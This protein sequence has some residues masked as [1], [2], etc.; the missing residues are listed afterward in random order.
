MTWLIPRKKGSAPASRQA[1]APVDAE[2]F[3]SKLTNFRR[4]TATPERFVTCCACARHDRAFVVV[5][6]R[7][8]LTQ[9][10][11]IASITKECGGSAA[12]SVASVRTVDMEQIDS[13]GWRCPWCDDATGLV[14]C[15]G[16]GTFVCRGRTDNVDGR[17]RFSCRPSCGVASHSLE[18]LSSLV[19]TNGL[20]SRPFTK[21]QASSPSIASDM[22]P[23]LPRSPVTSLLK[24]PTK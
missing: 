22:R 10:F 24:G 19:G 17:E 1:P 11:R 3:A 16:C 12:L 18:P 20:G 4:L 8:D 23:A 6:E 15:S 5:Y 7:F 9:P 14:A 21:T 13:S 2:A